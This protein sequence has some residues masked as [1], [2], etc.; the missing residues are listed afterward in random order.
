MANDTAAA[1]TGSA[2]VVE[3]AMGRLRGA[4]NAGIPSF[5]GIPYAAAPLGRNRFMP[6]EPLQPCAG[7]K[8]ALTY[9]G[10]AWQS[11]N[12]PARRRVL[13]TLLGPVDTTPESEDCLNLNIWTPGFGGAKRPVMVWLHGGVSD[14]VRA[15]AR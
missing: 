11:P 3:I 2:P 12:R 1:E 7:V 13:E 8:D 10:R 15:T 5:K 9:A 6:P 4:L 14:M